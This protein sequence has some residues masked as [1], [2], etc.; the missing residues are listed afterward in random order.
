MGADSSG[1]SHHEHIVSLRVTEILAAT[2]RKF[3]PALTASAVAYEPTATEVVM[4]KTER[5]KF[6]VRKYLGEEQGLNRALNMLAVVDLW[7]KIPGLG[8]VP[9]IVGQASGRGAQ[10]HHVPPTNVERVAEMYEREKR[11]QKRKCTPAGCRRSET[12]LLPLPPRN[13]FTD[14]SARPPAFPPNH[15]TRRGRPPIQDSKPS[16]APTSLFSRAKHSPVIAPRKI[17]VRHSSHGT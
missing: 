13:K 6:A 8:K 14:R 9:L 3:E 17:L 16:G 11:A 12:H 7:R 4:T 5:D 10:L 15:E 1:Q 2:L